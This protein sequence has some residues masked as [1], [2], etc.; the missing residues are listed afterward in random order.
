MRKDNGRRTMGNI[1]Y[2]GDALGLGLVEIKIAA[3]NV[4]IK[5]NSDFPFYVFHL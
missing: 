1:V 2:L 5:F 4:D 3:K